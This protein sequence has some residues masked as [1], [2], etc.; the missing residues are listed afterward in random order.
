MLGHAKLET[1]SIYTRVSM[2]K[3]KEIHNATHP[4]AKDGSGRPTE[5][6]EEHPPHPEELK[7]ALLEALEAEAA[8]DPEQSS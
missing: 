4:S 3:L 2:R 5:P 1:T 6:A 8:A 7:A